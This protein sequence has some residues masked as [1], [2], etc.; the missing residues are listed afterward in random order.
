M[1]APPPDQVDEVQADWARIHPGL[2]TTPMGI[3]GHFRLA[4]AALARAAEVPV[5]EEGLTRAEFDVLSA[6]RRSTGPLTPT[7]IAAATLASGAAT[8][9]RLDHLTTHGYLE[10]GPDARDGRV[11]RLRITDAGRELV[12]R[13]LPRVL[14]AEGGFAAVL[15]DEDREQLERILRALAAAHR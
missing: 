4:A 8:T 13:L 1:V 11:S 15:A 6:V 14:A 2:D 9:K 10:R 7:G 12:D 5:R 3:A